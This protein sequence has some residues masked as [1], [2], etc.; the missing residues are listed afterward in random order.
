ML[1]L[2]VGEQDR[3]GAAVGAGGAEVRLVEL[4]EQRLHLRAFQV[5]AG[6]DRGFARKQNRQ[7]LAPI[8]TRTLGVERF[9]GLLQR[10]LDPLGG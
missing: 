9:Q 10:A 8:W 7:A 6:L 4:L 3:G 1:E 5:L 2:T